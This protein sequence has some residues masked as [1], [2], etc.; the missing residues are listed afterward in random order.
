MPEKATL[1]MSY[2]KK[3]NASQEIVD[4]AIAELSEFVERPLRELPELFFS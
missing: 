4:F 3:W 1:W 2:R